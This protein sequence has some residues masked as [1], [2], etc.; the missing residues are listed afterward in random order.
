MNT[1]D[2]VWRLDTLYDKRALHETDAQPR[3]LQGGIMHMV[4]HERYMRH[5]CG[6]IMHM[7]LLLAND[8]PSSLNTLHYRP[9]VRSASSTV[10]SDLHFGSILN[11]SLRV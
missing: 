6:C 5:A 7:V 9:S 3:R 4:S 11:K 10:T 2:Y 1:S 8:A